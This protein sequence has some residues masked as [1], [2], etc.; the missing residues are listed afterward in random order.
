MRAKRGKPQATKRRWVFGESDQQMC[1]Q[2]SGSPK[3]RRLFLI[4]GSA[5]ETE[6]KV[7]LGLPR[8][9]QRKE[10]APEFDYSSFYAK[11]GG[12]WQFIHC[13]IE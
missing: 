8:I 12:D 4:L 11:T 5:H 13:G 7:R 6:N 10:N 3:M 1:I 2:T 9:I